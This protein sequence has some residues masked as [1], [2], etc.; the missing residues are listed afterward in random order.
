[1]AR[2][3][4]GVEVA[5]ALGVWVLALHCRCDAYCEV[6]RRVNDGPRR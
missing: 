1:M 6:L 2:L 5:A 3:L 4:I